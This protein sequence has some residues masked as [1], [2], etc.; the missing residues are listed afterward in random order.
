MKAGQ[1]VAALRQVPK[2]YS[3]TLSS[4]QDQAVPYHFK[5][6]KEVLIH[7]LGPE[8]S[9]MFLSLDEHPIA[10]ASIA[11]VHRG[12]LKGHQEV[13]IKVGAVPGPGAANE[14]RYNNHVFS[15]KIPCLVFPRIQI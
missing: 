1:F 13:A 9:D 4:L 5:A 12:V 8:L 6:I 11:Q 15:F 14:N 2:E 10:A 3:L 7:N